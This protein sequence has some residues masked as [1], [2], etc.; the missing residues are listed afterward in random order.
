MR[1]VRLIAAVLFGDLNFTHVRRK[2]W[3]KEKARQAA[4]TKAANRKTP[5]RK[6]HPPKKNPK[7]E[8][9]SSR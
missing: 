9:A 5:T 3:L 7:V 4:E 1:S 2:K 6:K 8:K